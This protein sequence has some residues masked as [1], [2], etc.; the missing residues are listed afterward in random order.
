MMNEAITWWRGK[1]GI[2]PPIGY[3]L[4]DHWPAQWTRFHSLPHSKR[5]PETETEYAELNR[6]ARTLA[7]T[8]FVPG[9]T[10]YA[11]HSTYTFDDAPPVVVPPQLNE[12]LSA[13]RAK[14]HLEGGD[15]VCYTRAL[16][17]VWPLDRFD[18]LIRHVADEDI[19]M[20]SFVAPASRNMMCP[21]DGGFDLFTHTLQPD[22]LREQFAEWLSDRP[23][24]L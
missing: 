5:Y 19:T 10:V 17:C 4:R 6:R 20:L 12:L 14:F 1:H 8:L 7:Q 16:A 23:D 22:A 18:T 3:E 15:A 9:E 2:L 21:Y 24:Y 11:F 13:S